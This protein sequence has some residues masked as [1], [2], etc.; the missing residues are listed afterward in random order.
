MKKGDAHDEDIGF[1]ERTMRFGLFCIA[2]MYFRARWL[3]HQQREC[4]SNFKLGWNINTSVPV[5]AQR[6]D[7]S[8]PSHTTQAGHQRVKVR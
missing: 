7:A 3:L 5:Q 6:K 1:M 8:Q 2:I 4:A